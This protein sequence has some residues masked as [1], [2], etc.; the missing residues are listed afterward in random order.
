M[1]RFLALLI[2]AGAALFMAT[3][4]GGGSLVGVLALASLVSGFAIIVILL[5]EIGRVLR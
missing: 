5:N 2:I 1:I 3:F 4:V